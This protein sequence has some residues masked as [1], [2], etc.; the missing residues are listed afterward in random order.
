MLLVVIFHV[1]TNSSF[2]RQAEIK[3]IDGINLIKISKLNTNNKSQIKTLHSDLLK[4]INDDKKNKPLSEKAGKNDSNILDNISP[5][6]LKQTNKALPDSLKDMKSTSNQ[7]PNLITLTGALFFVIFLILIFGGLYAK[8]QR[9]N[10]SKV[11]EGKFETT[12]TDSL[13]IL[14][15]VSLGQGKTVHLLEVN[16]EKFVVGSTNNNIN[17]IKDLSEK[18]KSFENIMNTKDIDVLNINNPEEYDSVYSDEYKE[19]LNKN[20]KEK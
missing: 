2:A 18:S 13:K 12:D 15:T 5:N 11:F 17:L 10:L 8:F 7:E 1:L 20:K 14:S 3:N 4:N 6:Q 19:Y 16:G 9:I